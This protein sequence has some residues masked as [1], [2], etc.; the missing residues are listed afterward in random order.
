VLGHKDYAR[1]CL[2][3]ASRITG[4]VLRAFAASIGLGRAWHFEWEDPITGA[5]IPVQAV[6]TN[7]LKAYFGA[8]NYNGALH[9]VQEFLDIRNLGAEE[10]SR[11]V[12]EL[13]AEVVTEKL[14]ISVFIS[15]R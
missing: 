10:F 14:F 4:F 15:I 9:L 13:T 3:R 8:T 7:R 11:V 12:S 5:H 1:D 6:L 2:Q